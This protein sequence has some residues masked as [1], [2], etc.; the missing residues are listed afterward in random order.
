MKNTR[1]DWID[2]M[3]RIVSP[4][5]DALEKGELRKQLPMTFHPERSYSAMLEAFGRSMLGIAPWLEADEE[6][7][8]EQERELQKAWREKEKAAFVEA[9][10]KRWGYAPSKDDI[11]Y[12]LDML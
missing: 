12:H 7:L 8:S 4:V 5:F 2:R 10:T 11:R 3:L 1:Q 6:S 9:F